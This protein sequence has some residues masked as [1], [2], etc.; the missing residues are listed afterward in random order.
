MKTTSIIK[1]TLGWLVLAQII[2][3][4]MILLDLAKGGH[5]KHSILVPYTVGICMDLVIAVLAGVLM[6]GTWLISDNKRKP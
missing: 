3:I 6:L 1:K 4:L 2:P 5:H